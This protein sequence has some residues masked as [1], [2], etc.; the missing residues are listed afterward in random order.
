MYSHYFGLT[1]A[2]FAISPNPRYLYMSEAHREALA[3]LLYGLG[4]D[5]CMIL[6]TGEV[7]TGKT[8]LCRCLLEQLPENTEVA[9]V[10][11]PRLTAREMLKTI[12]EEF[13]L[14]PEHGIGSI[15]T[16]IDAL[17]AHLL[18]AHAN[19]RNIAIIIDEAQ[20]LSVDVLEQLRLLTN[21][22][23][24]TRKLLRIILLGQPELRQMLERPEL[25]QINQRITSRYH[26]GP[27]APED[28]R[29]Y[30]DHRLK[31]AGD[32]GAPLFSDKAIRHAIHLTGGVPRLINVLCD[33]A[34]LGAYALNSDHVDLE[35]MRQAGEEIFPNSYSQ[36]R[37]RKKL[38]IWGGATLLLLALP[39]IAFLPNLLGPKEQKTVQFA[40]QAPEQAAEG[41]AQTRTAPTA[42]TE[43]KPPGE[44]V[45]MPESDKV[46]LPDQTAEDL[47]GTDQTPEATRSTDARAQ[48]SPRPAGEAAS[49]AEPSTP[50][51]PAT[52]PPSESGDPL[53]EVEQSAGN[54]QMQTE[55]KPSPSPPLPEPAEPTSISVASPYVLEEKA[56]PTPQRRVDELLGQ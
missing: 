53:G 7:G 27:L 50:A 30:I 55:E 17:N 54:K 12:C 40:E 34:L 38:L 2:P 4:S 45:L 42:Q 39:G 22:E 25:S 37:R 31:V 26:L 49:S 15:K 23:T 5:G 11:N 3:H 9:V 18:R 35:I 46:P 33:R 24:P 52:A 20:N 47:A 6:L 28:V 36:E 16:Y 51:V 29:A 21:L 19:D 48:D 43:E 8:T 44:Q 56:G 14:L 13:G 41:S 1:E 32:H 10:L